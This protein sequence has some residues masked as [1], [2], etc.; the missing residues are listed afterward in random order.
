M[1]GSPDTVVRALDLL[2]EAAERLGVYIRY[3]RDSGDVALAAVSGGGKG[4]RF[5]VVCMNGL[6]YIGGLSEGEE[7]EP[8]AEIEVASLGSGTIGFRPR[9]GTR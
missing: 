2:F 5:V 6:V 3:P 1:D 4:T 7:G 9:T 8:E